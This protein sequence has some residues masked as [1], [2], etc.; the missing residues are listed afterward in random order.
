MARIRVPRLFYDVF[1]RQ[2]LQGIY[3][4]IA[5]SNEN[6]KMLGR[7]ENPSTIFPE[8][9]RGNEVVRHGFLSGIRWLNATSE[10]IRSNDVYE[11]QILTPFRL[12]ARYL[13]TIRSMKEPTTT[14]R[15]LVYS[16][17][18]PFFSKFFEQQVVDLSLIIPELGITML[19]RCP[20]DIAPGDCLFKEYEI[21]YA[22]PIPFINRIHP[23]RFPDKLSSLGS[24]RITLDR[25]TFL[26]IS[27]KDLKVACKSFAL[28][29]YCEAESAVY[30]GRRLGMLCILSGRVK[31]VDERT[32]VLTDISEG[33]SYTLRL[34]P[35]CRRDVAEGGESGGGLAGRPVKILGIIWYHY[36]KGR[37]KDPEALYIQKCDDDLEA[38]LNDAAGY[39]RVRGRVGADIIRELYGRRVIELL[40]GN[41]AFDGQSLAWRH[42][43]SIRIGRVTPEFVRVLEWIREVRATMQCPFTPLTSILDSRKLVAEYY[44]SILHKKNLL[45]L[46]LALIREDERS[47]YLTGSSSEELRKR[48]GE[49][50][51]RYY[52]PRE[53]EEAIHLLRGM[54]LISV[55]KN[56]RGRYFKLSR[57]SYDVAYTAIRN[58]IESTLEGLL[59]ERG[60]LSV[61]DL[62]RIQNYPFSMLFQGVKDLVDRGVISP[63]YLY[64]F[65]N[66]VAWRMAGG[67]P[68]HEPI[69]KQLNSQIA[70]VMNNILDVL[71][72]ITHPISTDKL[73]E[74]LASKGTYIVKD[75]LTAL[76]QNLQ[77]QGRIR[78][79]SDNMWFYPWER[80][81]AD[82]LERE[83]TRIFTEGEIISAINP[84]YDIRA[85]IR[86]YLDELES[87]GMIE[88][89]RIR[90]FGKCFRWKSS[91]PGVINQQNKLIIKREAWWDALQTLR[92]FRRIDVET[93]KARLRVI[94]ATLIHQRGFKG[95]NVDEIADD[96]LQD[97]V[98]SGRV[99]IS[100]N[101][102]VYEGE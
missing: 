24:D 101:Y 61:F 96:V 80:R 78:Q 86:Q 47:G 29:N 25:Y 67:R 22:Q 87:R 19:Y 35:A 75:V 36:S 70:Q 15:G 84:P 9:V 45:P 65:R 63:L 91:D 51:G 83:Q 72:T 58:Q 34:S 39:I 18:K 13:L 44:S 16:V 59:G 10:F 38:L 62:V 88:R 11:Y 60:W 48:V 28:E 93:F 14:L 37:P 74:E 100:N 97:L 71:F 4:G 81:I 12:S 82:F 27:L 95:L 8:Q 33:D 42:E 31:Y 102:L 23:S 77:K 54:G 40:S 55:A 76:L 20:A 92:T 26:S 17:S 94:L 49:L 98:K 3:V 2:A 68:D 89:I 30:G 41:V 21:P 66:P 85:N 32:M 64:G 6:A 50:S 99:R 7:L 1:I 53:F 57:F 73:A 43:Q 69:L 56:S 90:G 79:T 52:Y 5:G 46:L